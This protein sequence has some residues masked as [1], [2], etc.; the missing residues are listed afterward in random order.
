MWS[1]MVAR[2]DQTLTSTGSRPARSAASLTVVTQ[3]CVVSSVKKVWRITSSK[4]RPPS[5]S[6]RG[7]KAMRPSGRGSSTAAR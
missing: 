7:P 3:R 2:H 4:Q 5:A 6:D 1:P